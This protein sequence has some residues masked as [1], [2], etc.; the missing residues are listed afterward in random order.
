MPREH[1]SDI[2]LLSRWG[3]GSRE[4]GETLFDRHFATVHRFFR[5]KVGSELED[6]VQQT[7][8]ACVEARSSFRMEASFKTFLLGIA[9]HQ[10]YTHYRKRRKDPVDFTLTSLRDMGTSPT[11]IL[12]RREREGLLMDALQR[13]P[14]ES[15][16]ILELA[17][18]E[19]LDGV[20]I[21]SVLSVPVNT[22]YSRLS[23]ARSRLRQLVGEASPGVSEDELMPVL[24]LHYTGPH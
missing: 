15:Q 9:R 17:Y 7:F 21:A 23:R 5:N 2:D 19:G 1:E 22:V 24:T 13:M 4:A 20:E 12:A 3:E 10:L 8:L 16:L 6:L 14:I 18:G 11:G